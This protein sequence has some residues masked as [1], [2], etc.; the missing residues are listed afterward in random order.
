MRRDGKEAFGRI[1][2]QALVSCPRNNMP[3]VAIKMGR[4]QGASEA[5]ISGSLPAERA[6]RSIHLAT[7]RAS[8][9]ALPSLL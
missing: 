7:R 8:H 3:F 4:R 2:E 6:Q 9:Y 5:P 1:T